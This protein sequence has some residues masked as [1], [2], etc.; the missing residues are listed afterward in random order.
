M[1]RSVVLFA[2]TLIFTLCGKPLFSQSVSDIRQMIDSGRYEAA[3]PLAEKLVS[4]NPK[5]TD[6]NLLLGSILCHLHRYQEAIDPLKIALSRQS[7][8]Y[9]ML[10]DAYAKTYDFHEAVNILEKYKKNL[11][12][13]RRDTSDVEADLVRM[14]R[15]QRLLDRTEWIEVIDSVCV[16]KSELLSAYSLAEDKGVVQWLPGSHNRAT[17]YLNARGDFAILTKS[18]SASYDLYETSMLEEKWGPER[19][20][21]NVNTS[22]NEN[23]PFL[24]ADGITLLFASDRPDGIGGYDLFVTRRDLEG[25]TFLN[26]TLLGMPFNSVYNDYLLVYDESRGIGFFASDRFCPLDTACVY[27]FVINDEV[28]PV[29]TNDENIKRQYA[30]LQNIAATQDTDTDYSQLIALARD[31]RTE[32]ERRVVENQI[33]FPMQG[34]RIYT[35]WSDFRNRVAKSRYQDTMARKK[36]LEEAQGRLAQLRLLYAE[37]SSSEQNRMKSEILLLER[38]I[39][40]LQHEICQ[41]EKE[42][43]NI[44]MQSE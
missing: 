9:E 33:Y 13:K 3:L 2:I 25:E 20:L 14:R 12:R 31:R 6:R 5:N 32:L 39:P 36:K 40:M 37:S 30:S 21:S 28:R 38:N 34:E 22:S 19:A 43:R 7:E 42:V 15:A 44:E 17:S 24:R 18:D 27:T 16:A 10:A 35:R 1:Y 29:A 8:A 26:P 41:M 4:K 23:Y 11:E